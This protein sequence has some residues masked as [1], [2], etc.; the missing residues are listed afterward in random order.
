MEPESSAAVNHNPGSN[1]TKLLIKNQ[2]DQKVI[3]K[4]HDENYRKVWEKFISLADVL[5]EIRKEVW[6]MAYT[7]AHHQM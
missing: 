2:T 1:S 5:P 6:L 7:A 4:Q 3:E